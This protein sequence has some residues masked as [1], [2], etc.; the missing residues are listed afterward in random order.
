VTEPLEPTGFW[1]YTRDDDNASAGRLSQLRIFLTNEL[2]VRFGKMPA[3]RIFQDVRTIPYGT[4]WDHEIGKALN[5]SSF[6]IPIVTPGFVQ[7]EMCCRELMRFRECEAAFGRADLIFPLHYIDTDDLNPDRDADCHDPAALRL[8]RAR[9]AFDFRDLRF[10]DPGNEQVLFRVA[11]LASAIRAALRRDAPGPDAAYLSL[12]SGAAARRAEEQHEAADLARLAEE[13]RQAAEAARVSEE[14]QNADELARQA[15]AKRKADEEERP[16]AQ[17]RNTTAATG[18]PQLSKTGSLQRPILATLATVAIVISIAGYFVFKPTEVPVAP[19]LPPALIQSPPSKLFVPPP[20]QATEQR[21]PAPVIRPADAGANTAS[22]KVLRD[23]DN[24][25][26]RMVLIP[27]GEFLMGIP[28]A[29][30]QREGTQSVD[31]DASPQH[32]V[33]IRRAFYLSETPITRGEYGACVNAG[34]CKEANRPSFG[35]TDSDPVVNVSYDDAKVY[36][37]WVRT[38]SGGKDYRLPTESEWEYSAR[39]GTATARYWGDDFDDAHPH[40]VPRSRNATMPVKSFPPNGFN[41]YD[42]LGNVRQW[43]ED[44]YIDNYNGGLPADEQARPTAG[45]GPRVIR[46]GSWYGYP[47][48]VRA[49]FR[50]GINS[51]DRGTT[52]GFRVARTY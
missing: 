16:A 19:R 10:R 38:V 36:I 39:A 12:I 26:P 41:L 6:F 13:K 24:G 35:Q 33:N 52:A 2:Q 5:Q 44:C 27:K 34:F 32:P 37:G 51:G 48:G 8:L 25:C 21:L 4:D 28:A 17:R 31:K 29:E 46:G 40:T 14:Q 49:G 15:E 9:Q 22:G 45:C 43:V 3:V 23:C 20:I 11:D 30:S 50:G 47:G 1:S 7:S 18:S 42:M